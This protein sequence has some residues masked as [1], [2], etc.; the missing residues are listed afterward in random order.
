MKGLVAAGLLL[1][2]V[3]T[4]LAPA[5]TTEHSP[6]DTRRSGL[7]FVSRATQ[8][9]QLDDAQNPAMLWLAEGERLWSSGP[10]SCAS[11][12]PGA[13]ARALR[14][15]ATRYPAWDEPLQR[16]LTLGQR[17]NQCRVRHQQLPP[18][19][20]EDESLLALETLAGHAS[21]GLPLAPST[22]PRLAATAVLGERLYRQRFGQL[23]FS[24]AMC[25]D[26]LAGQR[27]A[28]STIP[29]GHAA[30]YPIY[31]LEWQ[32]MGSLQ[33]R[34]RGCMTGIRAEPWAADA[35]EWTA[36]ELFLMRRAA[37]MT[38]ETPAVRP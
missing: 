36:L 21:R 37:G 1:A 20:R 13:P 6:V 12:H 30:G 17:I 29:Q 33:R 10:R 32:G 5:A 19:A 34:L 9:L 25:H 23:A 18:W 14:G 2:L 24:C 35:P 27:L 3:I 38:I 8:A 7:A 28:G 15:V 31:R 22:D 16:A 26:Q 11:C 4:G